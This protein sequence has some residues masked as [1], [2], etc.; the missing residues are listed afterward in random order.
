MMNALRANPTAIIIAMLYGSNE[1][2]TENDEVKESRY[3]TAFEYAKRRFNLSVWA[4][5][6]AV[7]GGVQGRW[8]IEDGEMLN[9]QSIST[10]ICRM[11]KDE[12]EE[13]GDEESLRSYQF[14]IGD[15]TVF[16]DFLQELIGDQQFG[17]FDAQ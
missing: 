12:A 3:K 8:Y 16:G 6:E 2:R 5:D 4:F 11:E 14:K 1:I 15:F 13:E 10:T 17:Q 9:A 7:I